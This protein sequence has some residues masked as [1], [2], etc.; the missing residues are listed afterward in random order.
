MKSTRQR[1]NK[2]TTF[3]TYKMKKKI[4]KTKKRNFWVRTQRGGG[5][6]DQYLLKVVNCFRKYNRITRYW[7]ENGYEFGNIFNN[8]EFIESTVLST[9]KNPAMLQL[10]A[11]MHRVL[12]KYGVE[13]E[14]NGFSQ[15][16]LN[17][18]NA[19]ALQ[20]NEEISKIKTDAI[21][22][23]EATLEIERLFGQAKPGYNN[24]HYIEMNSYDMDLDFL[25]NLFMNF[26]RENPTLSSELSEYEK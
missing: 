22:D 5:P 18:A 1:K 4:T 2:R 3:N 9:L 14:L 6:D 7:K 11:E 10:F 25:E 23:K 20:I 24:R 8:D 26:K 17:E 15:Y 19:L 12:Q 21:V 13:G 16:T